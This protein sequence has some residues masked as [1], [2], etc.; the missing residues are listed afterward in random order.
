MALLILI[1]LALVIVKNFFFNVFSLGNL[2]FLNEKKSLGKLQPPAP[3]LISDN[4]LS[5]KDEGQ[6]QD[7]QTEWWYFAGHLEDIDNSDNKFG[8]TLI[9]GKNPPSITVNLTDGIGRENFSAKIPLIKYDVLGE[10]NLKIVSGGNYWISS[11]DGGY[12]IHFAYNGIKIDLDLKPQKSPFAYSLNGDTFYY[13]QTRLSVSGSLYFSADK[14]YKVTGSGWID[15]QGFKESLPWKSWRWYSVQLNNNVEM[16]FVPEIY[17]KDG[18]GLKKN[19]LFIFRNNKEIIKSQDYEIKDL[20][21]WTNPKTNI[22]YPIKWQLD[23]PGHNTS[24]IIT[25]VIPNQVIDEAGG[26]YEGTCLVSGTFEG[27][28]VTGRAQ[29]ED[30]P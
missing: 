19:D 17:L 26:F 4:L 3:S 14:Q 15:H 9:F 5:P 11:P 25:A 16:A 13:Q 21:Y 29:F 28:T 24:L 27:Q 10:N 7:L 1:I 2:T 18:S 22:R 20:A 8:V 12:K 23:I 6:H 30:E